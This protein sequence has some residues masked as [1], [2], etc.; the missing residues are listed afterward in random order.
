[1]TTPALTTFPF[2]KVENI[3]YGISHYKGWRKGKNVDKYTVHLYMIRNTFD[4]TTGELT[5]SIVNHLTNPETNTGYGAKS[6]DSFAAA[7][8]WAIRKIKNITAERSLQSDANT[9]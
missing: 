2:A 7:A 5:S 3:N 1:M 4:K 9:I 6:F 8:G